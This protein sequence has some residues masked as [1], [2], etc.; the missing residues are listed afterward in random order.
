MINSLR[1]NC[2]LEFNDKMINKL[3]QKENIEDYS[4]IRYS[5]DDNDIND[6]DFSI[7]ARFNN[8]KEMHL[9]LSKK[10]VIKNGDL[11]GYALVKKEFD[12]CD[13]YKKEILE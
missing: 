13:I 5:I 11:S 2:S 9:L 10:E 12:V 8:N 7:I 1:K 6:N 4:V 3:S